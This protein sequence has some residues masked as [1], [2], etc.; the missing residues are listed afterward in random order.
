MINTCSFRYGDEDISQARKD[1]RR[2]VVSLNSKTIDSSQLEAGI[3]GEYIKVLA[4]LSGFESPMASR[5]SSSDAPYG[6][7]VSLHADSADS[8]D[9]SLISATASD[10][11][12]VLRTA[13]LDSYQTATNT[14]RLVIATAS[15]TSGSP[16][17][18]SKSTINGYS[19]VNISARRANSSDSY[20]HRSRV[21]DTPTIT[22][23]G[24]G[25]RSSFSRFS[26]RMRMLRRFDRYE[27]LLTLLVNHTVKANP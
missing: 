25:S 6:T 12:V 8:A 11:C 7:T 22:A 1:L 27:N 24:L 15:S 20:D 23:A 3:K 5:N 9:S 13:S 2:E 26:Y 18:A 19:P 10:N 4:Y 17:A 21:A 16:C 14:S